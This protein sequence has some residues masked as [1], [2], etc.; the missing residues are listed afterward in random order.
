MPKI[1]ISKAEPG[2]RLAKSITNANGV[3]MVQAGAELTTTL[4]ERLK[5]L[6][7]DAV[8][9]SGGHGA[10]EKPLDLMLRELDARFAG[11]ELDP[12]MMELK[13]IVKRRLQASAQAGNA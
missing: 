9:I 1:P 11:H 8:V 5:G 7:V 10:L 13:Q 3:T 2:Q 4:I 12:W 6:G